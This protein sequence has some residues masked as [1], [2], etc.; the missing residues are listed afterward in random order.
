PGLGV[1][2]A[3][4]CGIIRCLY[5]ARL[6]YACSRLV[7]GWLFFP[8]VSCDCPLS[9]SLRAPACTVG[10]P[11]PSERRCAQ[12]LRCAT[13]THGFW[14]LMSPCRPQA[15]AEGAATRASAGLTGFWAGTGSVS[16]GV[17][18]RQES[19]RGGSETAA[20][21]PRAKERT[22]KQPGVL[23][24]AAA[25]SHYPALPQRS[26]GGWAAAEPHTGH[27]SCNK[28]QMCGGDRPQD[29]TVVF[30]GS[31]QSTERGQDAP[32]SDPT[33]PVLVLSTRSQT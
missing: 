11:G 18:V 20:G 25:R 3:A 15:P 14:P 12:R 9:L 6:Q 8:M 16:E 10:S 26:N 21:Q 27:S 13:S 23:G 30:L 24:T 28:S 17:G 7:L 1:L 5:L 22:P 2:L 29:K 32:V 31:F 33:Q 19:W 4:S